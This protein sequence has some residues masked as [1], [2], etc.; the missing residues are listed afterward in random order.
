MPI[1]SLDAA[2]NQLN[3]ME[4]DDDLLISTFL[5]A[6]IGMVEHTIER[7]VYETPLDVPGEAVNFIVFSALKKSK[8]A[9]LEAAIMLALSTLYTY[10]ESELEVDLSENPAFKACLIGFSDVVVG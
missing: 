8:Q 7:D 4:G 3:V 6:A 10:R 5:H 1:V 9:A 2:K